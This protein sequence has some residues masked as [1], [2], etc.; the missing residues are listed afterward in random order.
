MSLKTARLGG[1]SRHLLRPA[2][3]SFLPAWGAGPSTPVRLEEL[4]PRGWKGL[5][6]TSL[7]A[8]AEDSRNLWVATASRAGRCGPPRPAP[9]RS[10]DSNRAPVRQRVKPLVPC[11]PCQRLEPSSGR[12]G[13]QP[14]CRPRRLLDAP[15]A[16]VR[17]DPRG[18][19]T[20]TGPESRSRPPR[21]DAWRQARCA[22]ACS[23]AWR[24]GPTKREVEGRRAPRGPRGGR[25]RA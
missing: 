16:E 21:V 1:W 18:A 3:S 6:A 11:L 25:D 20:R 15:C 2:L 22:P 17:A 5:P 9:L 14:H 13:A 24:W 12:P 8:P 4:S 19:R 10:A 23:P 7:P